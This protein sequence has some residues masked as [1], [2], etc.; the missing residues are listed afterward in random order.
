MIQRLRI[1]A[2]LSLAIFICFPSL[3][4]V[5]SQ[6]RGLAYG[7]LSE[8]DMN[9]LSEGLCWWYNW[10]PKPENGVASVF[11]NYNMGFVPMTWN[12]SF[13]ESALRTF[14]AAHPEAKF[15]LGFNEPNFKT[16][17]NMTPSQAAA[18]WPRLEKLA[19]D[20]GLQIV[21]PAVNYADQPVSEN[22][23]TYSDPVDYLDAFF[24]ACPNCKVDYIAVHNYMCYATALSSYI[25]RFR[26]YNRPVWLTEFACWDQ[27]TIT[28]DMQKNYMIDAM[29]FLENDSA[30]FRYSWFN[31]NRSQSYPYLDIFKQQSGELTDLGKIYVNF[32]PIHDTA[33]YFSVSSRIEAESYNAMSGVGLEIT[34]DESGTADVNKI[35]A[36][37]WL[38][39]Y[40][41]VPETADYNVFFRIA[42]SA[43]TSLELRENNTLLKAIRISNSGGKWETLKLNANLSAGKHKLQVFSKVGGFKLNWIEVTTADSPSSSEAWAKENIKMYPNPVTDKLFIETAYSVGKAQISVFDLSGRKVFETF[44]TGN[45]ARQTIDFS[46]F[47][48]GPYIVNVKN[49]SHVTHQLI[50]K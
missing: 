25:D 43:S 14:Y 46:S 24:A 19:Q 11:E 31:G 49:N 17:A 50:L 32:N 34:T 45:E 44:T 4:Q 40:V 8:A 41:E 36:N 30:I 33:M 23:V 26:K 21:S 20:F 5:K 9:V 48:S 3:A 22:G 12:G 16:Q 10:S 42:S 38:E 18:Q 35:D 28:V 7:Y 37:D 29:N 15:L 6:K 47:K 2:F 39:Y 13:N 27:P 1:A